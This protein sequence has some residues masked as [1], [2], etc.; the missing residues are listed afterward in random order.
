MP[1]LPPD[2]TSTFV[3]QDSHPA[4]EGHFVGNPL[5]PGVV[6]LDYV[7]Q[8]LAQMDESLVMQ[9]FSR[10]KFTRPLTPGNNLA[11]RIS[12]R[13]A[14]SYRFA[15]TDAANSSIASGEFSAVSG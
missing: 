5:V 9:R 10:V 2:F 13:D 14:G 6:I 4:T 12:A 3:I 15:C 11:V 8:A 7:R 1:S